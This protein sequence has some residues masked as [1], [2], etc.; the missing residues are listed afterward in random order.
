M[1]IRGCRI[2]EYLGDHPVRV[3]NFGL[4]VQGLCFVV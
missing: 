3:C 1:C 4:L 2:D